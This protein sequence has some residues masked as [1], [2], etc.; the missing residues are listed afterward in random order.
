[1]TVNEMESVLKHFGLSFEKLRKEG[2][3]L[4]FAICNRS[5]VKKA[6]GNLAG[7]GTEHSQ[8]ITIDYDREYDYVLV[9]REYY[10]K[11]PL[12]PE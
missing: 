10:D 8:R 1:M 12:I 4:D 5:D 2:K 9:R 6:T 7:Y 3:E 11:M